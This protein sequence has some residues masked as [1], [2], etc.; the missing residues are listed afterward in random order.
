MN[1]IP[2]TCVHRLRYRRTTYFEV[3]IVDAWH[4]FRKAYQQVSG[5]CRTVRG[6]SMSCT[7]GKVRVLGVNEMP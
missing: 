2:I 6:P 1:M 3:P 7:P 4:I 5:V